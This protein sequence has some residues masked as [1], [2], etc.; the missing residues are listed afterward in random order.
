MSL[1]LPQSFRMRVGCAY[2]RWTKR[3]GV[4]RIVAST[5]TTVGI[6]FCEVIEAAQTMIPELGGTI[7]D[8]Y[9]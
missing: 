3:S 6:T 5:G 9:K 2:D 4:P 1:D 7:T 8:E